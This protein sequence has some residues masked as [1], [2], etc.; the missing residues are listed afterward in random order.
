MMAK[1]LTDE[2]N[3][4][5]IAGAIRSKLEVATKFSP[6][7][8]AAAIQG[9]ESYPEPTG[10]QHITENGIVSVKDKEFAEVNVQATTTLISKTITQNGSYDADD[11]EA[12]GYSDVTVNVPNSYVAADEG[13]VVSNGELVAQMSTTVTQ[14]GTYDTTENNE[15]VVNVSGGGSSIVE[16]FPDY[17]K[18]DGAGYFELPYYLNADYKITVDFEVLS[19]ISGETVIGNSIG[20][21]KLHLTE[22]NNR[23]YTS[24]GT[25]EVNFSSTLV[26]R[27]TFIANDNGNNYFD[28]VIVSDYTPIT[29]SKV[30]LYI[31]Y[32]SGAAKFTGRIRS[33]K[34]ESISTGDTVC[35]LVPYCISKGGNE[36]AV[37]LYDMVTQSLYKALGVTTGY[38]E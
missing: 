30:K 4:K 9:I 22:Y 5:D 21:S 38:D 27:H 13:K 29:D 19:Y 12:D 2:Q 6:P 14:N 7:E 20:T 28:G 37:G 35:K 32:R 3:L 17:V 33:Y 16:E 10:T 25:S 36:L 31:G 8:M 15:V 34:I 1:V 24:N 23:W 26:G 11:D 18:L